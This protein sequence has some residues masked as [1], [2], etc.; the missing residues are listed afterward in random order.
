MHIGIADQ[1]VE[2][3]APDKFGNIGLRALR[4][5]DLCNITRAGLFVFVLGIDTKNL[6][7]IFTVNG[8]AV[9]EAVKPLDGE[10][11]KIVLPPGSTKCSGRQ[12]RRPG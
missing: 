7:E 10:S 9:L 12:R 3:Q 11:G 2:G 1:S 6:R 4:G 5:N 8:A